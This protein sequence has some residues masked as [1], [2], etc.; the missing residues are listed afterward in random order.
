MKKKGRKSVEGARELK[1]IPASLGKK[2]GALNTTSTDSM[3]LAM[4]IGDVPDPPPED[5]NG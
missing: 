4:S 5:T 1:A 2:K 3:R